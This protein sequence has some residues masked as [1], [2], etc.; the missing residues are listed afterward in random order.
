MRV[1]LLG[2]TTPNIFWPTGRP[3]DQMGRVRSIPTTITTARQKQS[4]GGPD[5]KK[6]DVAKQFICQGT[7]VGGGWARPSLGEYE[8]LIVPD[9]HAEWVFD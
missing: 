5:T 4:Y 7:G 3:D 1:T 2:P 8:R 6:T 9:P